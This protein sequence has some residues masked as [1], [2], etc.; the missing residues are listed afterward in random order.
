MSLIS[1]TM[2]YSHTVARVQVHD[3]GLIPRNIVEGGVVGINICCIGKRHHA[4]RGNTKRSTTLAPLHFTSDH[5]TLHKTRPPTCTRTIHIFP[6]TTLH[7]SANSISPAVMS[8]IF[9]VGEGSSD[10]YLAPFQY[11][12]A[13]DSGQP[14]S[15]MSGSPYMS[16]THRTRHFESEGDSDPQAPPRNRSRILAPGVLSCTGQCPSPYSLVVR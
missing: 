15:H 3:V 1:T 6:W 12:M 2:V 13:H 14:P 10:G 11:S 8:Q 5:Y 16:K 7:I 4:R 9:S